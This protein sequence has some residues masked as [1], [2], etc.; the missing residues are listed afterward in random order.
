MSTI[1]T[2]IADDNDSTRAPELPELLRRAA[3]TA[4]AE[5]IRSMIPASVAKVYTDGNGNLTHVDC[6]PLI[7]DFHRDETGAL[8]VDSVPVVS[9]VPVVLLSA[10]GFTFTC[11]IEQGTTGALFF[12]DLSL[13]A[14]LSSTTGAEVDPGLYTRSNLTDAIFVPGLQTLAMPSVG[15]PVDHAT[16]GSV[17]GKRIHFR[18]ATITIGDEGSAG[19]IAL[20]AKTLNNDN[21]LWNLLNGVFGAA[22]ATINTTTPGAPDA[23]WVAMKAAIVAAVGAGSLPPA[24]VAATVGKTE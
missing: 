17:S 1:T 24:S 19:F 10:G 16:A 6:K 15:A 2:D 9:N 22:S 20:A 8:I 12:S 5:R 23:V 18:S 11:P 4:M 3:V 13:D 14:W 21:A 7:M